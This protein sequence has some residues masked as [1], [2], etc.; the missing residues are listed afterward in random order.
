MKRIYLALLLSMSLYAADEGV[1]LPE[2]NPGAPAI[3]GGAAI[4][5]EQAKETSIVIGVAVTTAVA[6]TGILI[7]VLSP[8]GTTQHNSSRP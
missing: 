1:E 5:T 6:L 4:A 2:A 7:S 3:G 8:H